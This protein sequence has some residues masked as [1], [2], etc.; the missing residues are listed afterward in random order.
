M[1]TAPDAPNIFIRPKA[2]DSTLEFYWQPGNS[3]GSAILSYILDDGTTQTV[4]DSNLRY[5][6]EYGLANKTPYSYT[7]TASNGVGSGPAASFRTVQP[8]LK[9]EQPTGVSI[10]RI[11]ETYAKLSWF[12]ESADIAEP[13]TPT[14]W[15]NVVLAPQVI[16]GKYAYP[17]DNSVTASAKSTYGYE[18]FGDIQVGVDASYNFIV[19]AQNDP[20]YSLPYNGTGTFSLKDVSYSGDVFFI[21]MSNGVFYNRANFVVTKNSPSP[22]LNVD[23]EASIFDS[24]Y[25]YYP[26]QRGSIVVA[27]NSG[28]FDSIKFVNK[29]GF[30]KYAAPLLSYFS[31]KYTR[32]NPVIPVCSQSESAVASY[33]YPIQVYNY[34]TN[35]SFTSNITSSNGFLSIGS[36]NNNLD[37]NAYFSIA[38]GGV[39][40]RHYT[41]SSNSLVPGLRF[42]SGTN[43]ITEN[44]INK[45]MFITLFTL[46]NSKLHSILYIPNSGDTVL[47][48]ISGLEITSVP[49]S[50]AYPLSSKKLSLYGLT[51][52][53]SNV[54]TFDFNGTPSYTK[55]VVIT[56]NSPIITSNSFVNF[57]SDFKRSLISWVDLSGDNSRYAISPDIARPAVKF[58]GSSQTV[59]NISANSSFTGS[60]YYNDS[61]NYYFTGVGFDGYAHTRQLTYGPGNTA[62]TTSFTVQIITTP[63]TLMLTFS[64]GGIKPFVLIRYNST[65]HEFDITGEDMSGNCLGFSDNSG[66]NF[67]SVDTTNK[68]YYYSA[69]VFPPVE[70]TPFMNFFYGTYPR[71][72]KTMALESGTDIFH[73]YTGSTFDIS[74]N[75]GCGTDVSPVQIGPDCWYFI[76]HTN[77]VS[78]KLVRIS[79]TGTKVEQTF[80]FPTSTG[81]SNPKASATGFV[82][83]VSDGVSKHALFDYNVTRN[84]FNMT[85]FDGTST[86]LFDPTTPTFSTYLPNIEGL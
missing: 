12:N 44:R 39:G 65:T 34:D 36:Y 48:D 47:Y 74:G 80:S 85:I 30:L 38:E 53:D 25:L 50:W 76:L 21:A 64:D 69:S 4:L 16:N 43:I 22:P 8:G 28:A 3:N 1:A 55:R 13:N 67:F 6:K 52:V 9:P 59:S 19:R 60:F 66:V 23:Q 41:I 56:I 79:N 33:N 78:V 62:I 26:N 35:T 81:T 14:P 17:G 5:Y 61:F 31:S 45:E 82:C 29:N 20:G 15:R 72:N 68:S 42:T 24:S 11:S 71:S 63:H 10:Y 70:I 54:Y 49:N 7:L 84:T 27:R 32:T 57:Y 73:I 86:G 77:G 46:D 58:Y 75:H 51:A 40:Y 37:T 2:T 18:N 83:I